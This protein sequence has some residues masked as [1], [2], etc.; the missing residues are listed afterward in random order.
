[1]EKFFFKTFINNIFDQRDKILSIEEDVDKLSSVIAEMINSDE[2]RIIF[3][4]AGI[5]PE[6]AQTIINELWFNFQ[7]KKDKF[8]TLVAAKSF[9]NNLEEWKEL[10][11]IKSTSIFELDEIGLNNN[12]LVIGLSSSGKT[13]Y[14]V[15]SLKYAKDLGCKTAI[16]TNAERSLATQYSDIVLNTNQNNPIVSNLNAAEGGTIQKIALDSII[17]LAMVKIGRIYKE[18]LVFMKPVSKKIEKY[19]IEAIK[20]LTDESEEKVIST[21]NAMGKNMEISTL[22]LLKDIDEA[23]AR[24]LLKDNHNNFVKAAK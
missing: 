22:S 7:I 13:E 16:L 1:M 14:V 10:E 20:E 21:F 19:C 15:S 18:K 12:D 4:G 8:I 17:Y 24:K 5:S 23:A 2:G 11:E 9:I 3:I 6:I